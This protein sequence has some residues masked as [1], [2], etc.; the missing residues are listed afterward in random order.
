LK[1]ITSLSL[2]KAFDS[3]FHQKFDFSD[4]LQLELSQEYKKFYIR[5]K[6]ILNPSV[7]L[8]RYLRFLNSFIF[9]YAKINTNV[10]HSYRQ[11]KNAYTAV[12]KHANSKYFFQTDIQSFFYRITVQDVENVLDA[13]LS[14]VPICDVGAFKDQ[15]LNLVTVNDYL[16]VGF[17]TSPSISNTCLYAFDNALEGY[18]LKL[19][20]VY[21]RYS[22]D[23]IIS[24]MDNNLNNIQ[25]V[26]SEKL[27]YF[28]SNRL[29]LNLNKTKLTHKGKK[30]KLLGMVVLP[31]GK[32]SVDIKVKKQ[33]EILLHFYIND[34]EKFSDYLSKHYDGNLSAISGQL[35]YISTIDKSYLNKLRKKYGN[36][37]VD[38]FFH[39][40][41]K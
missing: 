5:D 37:I 12:L 33:L 38:A 35:N 23:I 40:T 2:Q 18:C 10:V 20:V 28:F 41:V 39:K 15:L 9:N 34:M 36:F 8:K 1:N 25:N 14:D 7:K 29:Q 17:S 30:I 19:G 4:F 3:T 32:V 21:T 31:S 6:L 13:N 22:D 24:S 16:P 27:N 11:G 26:V